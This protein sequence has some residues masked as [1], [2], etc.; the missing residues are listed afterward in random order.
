ML[1]RIRCKVFRKS[2]KYLI[3]HIDYCN[4]DILFS[5]IFRHFQTDKSAAG[6]NYSLHFF[7]FHIIQNIES[8]LRCSHTEH[9]FE[10][11]AFYLRSDRGGSAGN[12][13]SVV[14]ESFFFARHRVHRFHRM[15]LRINTDNL[16]LCMYL[17]TG[18]PLKALRSVNDQ[19]RLIADHTAQ[20]IGQPASGVRDI[21]SFR[22]N[23]DLGVSH[24]SFQFCRRFCPCSN[25]ADNQN[26]HIF[27]ILLFLLLCISAASRTILFLPASINAFANARQI[28]R[29][30]PQ[31]TPL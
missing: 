24:F 31:N 10:I 13:Q 23:S 11:H 6:H 18:Q 20:I 29:S 17:H 1:F 27:I 16:R 26:F 8:I 22:Q 30:R 5:Q 21:L 12:Y 19:C 2:R 9:P 3:R 25:P 4:A 7:L 28:L 14:T 15:I